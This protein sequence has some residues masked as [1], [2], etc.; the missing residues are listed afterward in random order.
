MDNAT[1]FILVAFLLFVLVILILN[2]GKIQAK[3]EGEKNINKGKVIKDVDIANFLT[4]GIMN[5]GEELVKHFGGSQNNNGKRSGGVIIFTNKRFIFC[6][7]PSGWRAKGFDVAFDSS[8]GDVTSVTT[9]GMLVK[10]LTM[11]VKHNGQM[12]KFAFSCKDIE[13]RKEEIIGH[14]HEYKDGETIEAKTVIIKEANKDKAEDILKKR[15]ARGEI[16]LDEF[17][18]KIQRT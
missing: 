2:R 12:N 18:Q 6:V 11:T 14:K 8:W 5:K 13:Q 16:T 15:L 3:D 1:V 10:K 9:S 17:H 4:S 7:K